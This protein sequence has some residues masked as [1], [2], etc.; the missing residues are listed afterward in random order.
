MSYRKRHA[1]QPL[2]ERNALSSSLL[3]GCLCGDGFQCEDRSIFRKGLAGAPS[4]E[5]EFTHGHDGYSD[6]TTTWTEQCD[7]P[8]HSRA[9]QAS[10][11]AGQ[12]KKKQQA[13]G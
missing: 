3:R 13:W 1:D 5:P 9:G 2:G 11:K 6:E 8:A 10:P 12:R 4:G 7:D